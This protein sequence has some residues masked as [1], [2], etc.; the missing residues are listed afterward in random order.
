[1]GRAAYAISRNLDLMRKLY[2]DCRGKIHEILKSHAKLDEKGYPM[3]DREQA[4]VKPMFL[5]PESEAA[6][7]EKQEEFMKSDVEVPYYSMPVSM[8]ESINGVPPALILEINF[9]IEDENDSE[10]LSE[11]KG[12]VRTLKIEQ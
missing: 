7:N 5:T 8:V 2:L 12:S 1:N 9:L 3:F 11:D 10:N 4:D 6:F